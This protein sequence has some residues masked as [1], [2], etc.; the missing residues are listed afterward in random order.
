MKQYTSN[1]KKKI[2]LIINKIRNK[3]AQ[4]LKFNISIRSYYYWKKQLEETGKIENESRKPKTSPKKYKNKKII[5]KVI[6]IRKKYKYGK[7]K[8]KKLLEKEN[9]KIG[10]SAIERILKE[11]N[12]YNKRKKK[13]R[14]K[15]QGKHAIYIKEAGEKVQI[16]VKYAFFGEIRY[17]QFTA[18]D[19]ATRMSFRY[20][21]D[22]KTPNS[23]IDFVKRML[24][25]FPFRIHS[26]QTD[27]GTEFTYRK[28]LFDTVHPLDIFCKKNYI[29]RVYSPVASPW[30]NG[31]VES[32]HKLDQKEF[33]DFCTQELTLEKANMKL[34]KYNNFFNHK[35]IHSALNYDTP[36]LYFKKLRNS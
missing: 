26:I 21:Y 34:R 36:M 2:V 30:Y 6:E 27:N 7:V 31:I 23:T 1:Q 35:R 9:I 3:K 17:Y 8:I 5:N 28:H 20:L 12:L 32:T 22:E 33:Y 16:D 25:Y 14:K 13:I 19:V 4:A 11:H 10:T 18:V 24:D 15:H 29:K